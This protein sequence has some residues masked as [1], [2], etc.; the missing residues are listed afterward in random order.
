MGTERATAPRHS[1]AGVLIIT[2]WDGGPVQ[3]QDTV[4]CV[5][6]GRHWIWKPGSGRRRG[7]CSLCNGITC[8]KKKCDRCVPIEQWLENVEKGRPEDH[9]NIVVAGGWDGGQS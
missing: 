2:P 1:R 8:G 5:H 6:C 7:W 3:M 9:R 4:Q